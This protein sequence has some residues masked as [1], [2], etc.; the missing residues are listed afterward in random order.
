MKGVEVGRADSAERLLENML[1][2]PD[3]NAVLLEGFVS[4]SLGR[5]DLLSWAEEICRIGKPA[6]ARI[7]LYEGHG[8]KP[9]ESFEQQLRRQL[10]THFYESGQ[11]LHQQGLV[12]QSTALANGSTG[13]LKALSKLLGHLMKLHEA[14]QILLVAKICAGGSE[15]R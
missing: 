11:A 2:A 15:L 6:Q 13:A 7:C 4:D 14:S 8:A 10:E 9:G 12:E 3:R 5:S 1:H